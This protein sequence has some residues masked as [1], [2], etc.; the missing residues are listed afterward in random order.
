ME[1]CSFYSF[2][3]TWSSLISTWRASLFLSGLWPKSSVFCLMLKE[4]NRL[5]LPNEINMP[6]I[7]LLIC[8]YFSLFLLFTSAEATKLTSDTIVWPFPV[9]L[10]ER[11]PPGWSHLLLLGEPGPYM[12]RW[13]YA[14]SQ[15]FPQVAFTVEPC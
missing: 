8:R 5:Q 13:H 10:A 12:D 3:F 1:P 4:C 7:S 6:N 9:F 11:G 2:W 14:Y 15:P